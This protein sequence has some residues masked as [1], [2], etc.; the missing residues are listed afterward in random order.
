VFAQSHGVTIQKA[1]TASPRTCSSD[2]DCSDN[3]ACNGL[4][5]CDLS[6]PNTTVCHI[7]VSNAD[8]FNDSITIKN[9]FDVIKPFAADQV[10]VPN[11]VVESVSG[12]TTCAVGDQPLL[13]DPTTWC[14][15]GPDTGSGVGSVT[16]ISDSY[17][18]LATDP[19]PLPDQGTV[20]VADNCDGANTANCNPNNA[21]VSF[22][23]QSDLQS[24][25]VP[26]TPPNCDDSNACTTDACDPAT[27]CTN[28]PISCEDN[29]AC[30]ADSCDP[31]TGCVNAPISCD[32]GNACTLDACDPVTGCTHSA[33]SCDDSNACTTD[34]CDP[35][36]G[37]VNT[38][39]S[40]DDSNACTT[41]ACD[42]ATG[43]THSA[44]SCDDSNA[45]TNDACDPATGCTHDAISCDDADEC[46]LD[47]CDP[48]TGCAHAP[49]PACAIAPGCRVTAGGI[50]PNGRPDQA[51]TAKG[52]FGGQVGAPCGCIG[53]FEDDSHIQGSWQYSRKFGGS[54]HVN[55]FNSLTCECIDNEGNPLQVGELCGDRVVGPTPP[56]APANAACFT[57]VGS[58]TDTQGRRTENVVFRIEVVDRGEPGAGANAGPTSDQYTISIWFPTVETPTEELLQLVACT[59][60]TA[61]EDTEAG[62]PDIQ[63]GGTLVHGNIQI[64]TQTPNSQDGVC[65]VPSGSCVID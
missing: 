48:A 44:I 47:S 49:N 14:V 26:G 6:I 31:V 16:F 15:I 23:S 2:A 27:G 38:S 11:L 39:I 60:T 65:P 3:N 42:P 61:P 59:N 7:T 30:T 45:C 50:A 25:C 63:D 17:V 34:S 19:D 51:Q 35:V 52:T 54:L 37:C 10:I 64:H 57:G 20:T 56:E 28:T 53:A 8:G 46:T 21:N 9:A 12:N 29:N 13:A 33:I 24:G 62:A 41:D 18:V 58:W 32:D 1:C 43:C 5:T 55:D 40:C 36:T 4:E 22:S